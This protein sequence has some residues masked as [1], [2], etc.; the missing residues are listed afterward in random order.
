MTHV[1]KSPYDDSRVAA[2]LQAANDSARLFRTIFVA[3][4]VAVFYF[5]AVTLSVDDELLF[6][7]GHLLAP[8][9]NLP[10]RVSYYFMAAPWVLLLLHLNL[11]IQ[12]VFVVRKV[13]DYSRALRHGSSQETEMLRL[14]FPLPLA[15]AAG[16]APLRRGF[17]PLLE[18]F[19]LTTLVLVPLLALGVMQLQFL[20]F[21][22]GWVTFMQSVVLIVDLV[23]V[24]LLWPS[25]RRPPR[26]HWLTRRFGLTAAVSIVLVFLSLAYP[27]FRLPGWPPLHFVDLQGLHSLDVQNA[28]LYSEPESANPDEACA[29]PLSGLNL[30]GRSYRN[31][32][33]S[34][35]TLCNA[36]LVGAQLAGAELVGARLHQVN[37]TNS[38]LRG[39]DLTNADLQGALLTSAELQRASL[40]GAV[41]RDAEA[42]R[43]PF[44]LAAYVLRNSRIAQEL[45]PARRPDGTFDPTILS[46]YRERI[47]DV[48][49]TVQQEG[50]FRDAG[51]RLQGA[52]LS[53]AQLQ[54]ASLQG[55][56]MQGANLAGAGLQ[57]V[58][59]T[60]ARL[61]GADLA[62][63]DAQ[64][65]TLRGAWLPGTN[66]RGARF[67]KADLSFAQLQGA[68]AP[69]AQ[70]LATDCVGASMEGINLGGAN[71]HEANVLG[72]RLLGA[73]AGWAGM[74]EP[75]P[76][77]IAVLQ[78]QH[79]NLTAIDLTG[80]LL[81]DQGAVVGAY[82]QEEA[83]GWIDQYTQHLCEAFSFDF[84]TLADAPVAY[85]FGIAE[86][87]IEHWAAAGNCDAA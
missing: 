52:D 21:Q 56:Q 42:R 39:A 5:A 44:S 17:H 46:E 86:D 16:G 43:P 27:D 62:G 32:K 29:D 71:L 74:V 58:D 80:S 25:L 51:L 78:G 65:A 45:L 83:E 10:I 81:E 1:P 57:G 68:Y 15:H 33:L 31:A 36:N 75:F 48:L 50:E 77:T 7:D 22:L 84:L 70:L 60:N 6:R 35:S 30:A 55:A 85:R 2:L 76:T 40:R 64:G 79:T 53:G 69:L 73:R 11:L 49:A 8:L 38:N 67:E 61:H 72:A 24:G 37:L 63:V 3:F 82:G 66:L 26:R 47:D 87:I 20:G 28:R 34:G 4:M 9:L 23:L 14:L 19:V 41:L 18:L 59:F 13:D 12:G 54:D